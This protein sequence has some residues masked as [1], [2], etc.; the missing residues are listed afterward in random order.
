MEKI[1]LSRARLALLM[2][3]KKMTVSDLAEAS[4]CC[5][6]TIRRAIRIGVLPR[7]AGCIAAALGV[8]A[9]AVVAEE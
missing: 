7:T 8:E 1:R 3:E 2:A 4:G 9:S 6:T 5:E